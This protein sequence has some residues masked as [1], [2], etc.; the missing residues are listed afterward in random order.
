MLVVGEVLPIG[1]VV[2]VVLLGVVAGVPGVVPVV[3]FGVV[4]GLVG[5]VAG[6]VDEPGIVVVVEVLGVVAGAV[7]GVQSPELDEV[8]ALPVAADVPIVLPVGLVDVLGVVELTGH[9]LADV[10]G[11]VCGLGEAVGLMVLEGAMPPVPVVRGPGL[12]VIDGVLLPPVDDVADVCA[13]AIAAAKH[14]TVAQM[15]KNLLMWNSPL[16]AFKV[17]WRASEARMLEK[18][19]LVHSA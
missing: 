18:K 3:E 14:T 7:D 10:C 19:C 9:E 16:W 13:T 4:A 1:G 6:V 5:V 17:G 11:V 8:V 2:P 12:P 15:S